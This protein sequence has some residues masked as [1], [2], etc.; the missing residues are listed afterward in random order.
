MEAILPTRL[1]SNGLRSR[2]V[3]RD[4]LRDGESKVLE[5]ASLQVIIPT[6]ARGY[7]IRPSSQQVLASTG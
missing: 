2:H 3:R 6:M 1:Q 5:V 7:V 4:Q